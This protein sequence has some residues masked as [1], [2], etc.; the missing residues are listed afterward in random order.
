MRLARTYLIALIGVGLFYMANL[1]LPWLLGPIFTSLVAALLGVQLQAFKP[2]HQASRTILG[3]AVGATITLALLQSLF[4]M[5]PSLLLIIVMVILIGAIG[6]PYFMKVG[7]YDLATSYYAAMPG[8]LQDILVFGEEAGANLRTLSLIHATRVLVIV[9]VLPFLLTHIWHVDLSNPPGLP[10]RE[11][12][13]DQLLW[14]AAA[15]LLG[16]KIAARLG[17]FG[18]TILGPLIAAAC[19][20]LT[21]ILHMRPPAEAIWFAQ[22]FIGAGLGVNYV[23]ISF[24]ELKHD[25]WVACLFC[26][27]LGIITMIFYEII[28][29]LG[30]APAMET[31][32]AFT[33]G[34]QAEMTVLALVVGADMGFV[35]A[36]H[37][38]RIFVVILG[39]PLVAKLMS[40]G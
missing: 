32:L 10:L 14:S 17:L 13:I 12:A 20:S 1:P 15:A 16:W 3:V 34:G 11:I 27:L 35:I 5:W 6:V 40:K 7:G 2:V 39:A 23:G 21:G 22:F 26:V 8:G 4:L 36:H 29:L 30:I 38:L 24:T 28:T 33:P 19:L 37:V 9:L 25:V 31:L 18:A